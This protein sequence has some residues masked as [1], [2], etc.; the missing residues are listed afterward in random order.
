[1]R[2][3]DPFTLLDL[4]FDKHREDPHNQDKE[5]LL[6]DFFSVLMDGRKINPYSNL[7]YWYPNDIN[8]AK[9]FLFRYWRWFC[10]KSKDKTAPSFHVA[11]LAAKW[12]L[13]GQV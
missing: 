10:K 7:E 6:F 8:H 12:G 13:I 1:M 2:E 11:Y 9:E 3:L 5:K 4:C